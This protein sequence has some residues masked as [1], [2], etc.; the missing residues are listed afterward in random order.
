M[1]EA[2]TINVASFGGSENRCSKSV[3]KFCA[4]FSIIDDC[5]KL[6][7]NSQ[8]FLFIAAGSLSN[9]SKRK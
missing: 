2:G 6:T 5:A 9:D 4:N 7:A 8:I 1:L 3:N